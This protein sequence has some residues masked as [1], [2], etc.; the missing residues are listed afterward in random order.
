MD[1]PE[2]RRCTAHRK[3]GERC[4]RFAA[5]G[6]ATCVMHGSG[7]RASRQAGARRV[8]QARLEAEAART[9]ATWG[10]RVDIHPAE[11]L[12]E[13]VQAKAA[14]VAYWRSR[15]NSLPDEQLAGLL[16]AKTEIGEGPQG[17]VDTVTRQ[18]GPHVYVVM[19][20]KA[21]DML[22]KFCADA[23]RAG[24]TQVMVDIVKSQGAAVVDFAR[25]A[26]LLSRT[27]PDTDPDDLILALLED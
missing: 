21:E 11:A 25:R 10:G 9:V 6:C 23:I 8:E 1:V 26:I 19:L 7:N 17:P 5:V 22:A 12:L 14:E 18:A 20:H 16:V 4:K 27:R 13:L 15:T 3:N 24:A 2:E